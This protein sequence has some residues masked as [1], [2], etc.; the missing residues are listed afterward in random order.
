MPRVHAACRFR[1]RTH[2]WQMC[3]PMKPDAPVTATTPRSTL[4]IGPHVTQP[5]RLL[6][7]KPRHRRVP[8]GRLCKIRVCPHDAALRQADL[9]PTRRC[10]AQ[11]SDTAVQHC[12]LRV[13]Q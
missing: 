2:A 11:P 7:Q 13:E 1:S 6:L 3:E 9:T 10:T 12:R 8:S 5:D 4:G